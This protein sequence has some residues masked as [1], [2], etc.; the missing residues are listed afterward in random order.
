MNNPTTPPDTST[1]IPHTGGT[2]SFNVWDCTNNT[3][4]VNV[5]LE[6]KFGKVEF[7]KYD[8][9]EYKVV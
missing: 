5:F 4:K 8:V 3:K 9:V 6:C 2:C 7:C 1:K